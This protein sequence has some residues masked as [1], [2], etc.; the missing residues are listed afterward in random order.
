MLD[1]AREM[2]PVMLGVLWAVSV[3]LILRNRLYLY[4]SALPAGA[5]VSTING[6]LSPD[7]VSSLTAVLIDSLLVCLGVVAGD[8]VRK[9]VRFRVRSPES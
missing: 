3:G 5:V 6:E 7:V 8:R 2:L 9:R 1:S 4:L